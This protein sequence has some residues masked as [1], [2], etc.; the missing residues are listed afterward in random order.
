MD[1]EKKVSEEFRFVLVMYD[2]KGDCRV[3]GFNMIYDVHEYVKKQYFDLKIK[4][5]EEGYKCQLNIVTF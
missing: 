2:I 3:K 5:E 1:T 4:A